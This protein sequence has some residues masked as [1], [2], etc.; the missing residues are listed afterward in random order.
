MKTLQKPVLVLNKNWQPVH[1]AT[2]AR[3]LILLWKDA[4]RVVDVADYQT[5]TWQDWAS[6]SPEAGDA[7]AQNN[8][9]EWHERHNAAAGGDRLALQWYRRAADQ[10]LPAAMV[11]AARLLAPAGAAQCREAQKLLDLARSAGLAQASE[12]R[13]ALQCAH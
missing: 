13:E 3:A 2:V 6:M 1:V 4:A 10:G 7:L 5:F 8:L 9:G 11:N 12:W